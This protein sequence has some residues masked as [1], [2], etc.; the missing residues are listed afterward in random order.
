MGLQQ[1][2]RIWTY[3]GDAEPGRV[4]RAL[5]DR[6][7]AVPAEA[8]RRSD[9]PDAREYILRARAALTKTPTRESYA[10]AIGFYDRALAAEPR[11]ID[12]QSRL[13]AGLADRVLDGFSS[14]P[15]EDIKRGEALLAPALV[16]SAT[17][18]DRAC[19]PQWHRGCRSAGRHSASYRQSCRSIGSSPH[20]CGL[21]PVRFCG[22]AL[23]RRSRLAAQNRSFKSVF[24]V[25]RV[26]FT[27]PLAWKLGFPSGS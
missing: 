1:P 16:A 18:A 7:R 22:V 15:A 6:T 3:R 17:S 2:G 26:A 27:V 19:A 20:L 11:S 10:E 4:S 25:I 14:S 21:A 24:K 8:A 12:A 13:A 9:K 5:P 23:R